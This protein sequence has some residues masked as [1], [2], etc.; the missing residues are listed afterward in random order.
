MNFRILADEHCERRAAE[1]LRA[2][3]HDVDRIVDVAA[4]G[5]GSDDAA[6]AAHARRTDRV[7]LTADDDFLSA[8]DPDEPPGVLFL[9]NERLDPDRLAAVVSTVADRVPEE[10]FPA[11]V[12]VT[13]GWL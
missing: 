13:D 9:P 2:D 5:P 1:R 6:V 8:F 7:V 11:V 4:L 12:Y 3:G 10:A